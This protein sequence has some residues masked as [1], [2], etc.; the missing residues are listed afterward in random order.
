MDSPTLDLHHLEHDLAARAG[1]RA[2]SA[3]VRS[4][5]EAF[6][7]FTD[8]GASSGVEALLRISHDNCRF[9]LPSAG[10]RVLQ[11][12]DEVR[13]FFSQA[14]TAGTSVSVRPRSF[15]EHGEEVVV[16][17]SMRVLRASGGFAE[18]QI[19]WIYRFRDGLVE[20]ADW[21]PRHSG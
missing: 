5:K 6:R 18:S 11:G 15:E 12:A 16:S 19:R 9:R 8:G 1:A 20:D 13:A 21:S 4:I 3:N 7:A 10:E 14:A 2:D 17:G